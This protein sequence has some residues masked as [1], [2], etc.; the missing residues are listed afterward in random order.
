ME[1]ASDRCSLVL[2]GAWNL[3]IF[4]PE[5]VGKRIFP[6]E[7][8][9]EF[10]VDLAGVH[11]KSTSV[12]FVASAGR[13]EFKP[14]DKADRSLLATEETAKATLRLLPETPLRACGLNIA[15]N[16]EM[17]PRLACIFDSSDSP[18]LEAAGGSVISTKV[19][20]TIE[21]EGARF[22]FIAGREHDASTVTFDFNYHYDLSTTAQ[23]LKVLDVGILRA[24]SSCVL[25]LKKTYDL[26]AQG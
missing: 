24:R 22:N 18:M 7:A 19:H 14:A 6:D 4:H 10:G 23:A 15:C 5:W 11:F 1:L 8:E 2:A 17:S 3:A 16:A 21:F 26:E 12:L 13:L 9:F 20:R 25:F